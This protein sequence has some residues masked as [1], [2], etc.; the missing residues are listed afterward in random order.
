MKWFLIVILSI[1]ACITYGV[2]H[3]QIT[4]RICVEYFTV[5]H[6][7]VFDTVDPTLDYYMSAKEAVEYGVVD[8]IIQKTPK[9]TD[10]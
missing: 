4:A 10:K 9:D 6:A 1:F 3:D 2:V 8:E 7:P 5:G